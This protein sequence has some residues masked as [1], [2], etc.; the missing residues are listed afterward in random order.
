MFSCCSSVRRSGEANQVM[1]RMKPLE[2][3]LP[4]RHD[5]FSIL[6]VYGPDGYF[7]PFRSDVDHCATD[8]VTGLV[9]RLP[10]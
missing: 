5:G 4:Y 10:N 2:L 6:A 7:I 8:V 1:G 9:E 3:H